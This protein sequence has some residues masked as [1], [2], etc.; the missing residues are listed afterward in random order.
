MAGPCPRKNRS[1]SSA[2]AS[3][4][5]SRRGSGIHSSSSTNCCSAPSRGPR[6]SVP[7]CDRYPSRCGPRWPAT[8]MP[9]SAMTA[10]SSL[11][12]AR[13]PPVIASTTTSRARS[14][15]ASVS[16]S[17]AQ[18]A[19][20]PASSRPLSSSSIQGR[21]SATVRCSVPR[22]GHERTTVPASRA[23]STADFRRPGVLSATDTSAPGR[24]W[25]W[26]AVS[27][28]TTSTTDRGR[29]PASRWATRRSRPIS[30][31]AVTGPPWQ[32][33]PTIVDGKCAHRG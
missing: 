1:A 30:D 28:R 26:T 10:S 6:H 21:S 13:R 18:R 14:A 3:S 16:P 32:A 4:R 33:G 5:S 31:G 29:G 23:D 27:R 11:R 20:R 7:V 15:I 9:P 22:I 25:A 8:S 19:D 24:S 17:P 12:P 2:S